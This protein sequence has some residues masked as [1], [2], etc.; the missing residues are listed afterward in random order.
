VNERPFNN[1]IPLNANARLKKNRTN[2]QPDKLIY[3]VN[4]SIVDTI[5]N[6]T[7]SAEKIIGFGLRS[8]IHVFF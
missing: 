4:Q 2:D 8:M 5:A 1:S 3:P 7:A 6:N